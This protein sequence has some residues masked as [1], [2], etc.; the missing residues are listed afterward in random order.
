MSLIGIDFGTTNSA[1]STVGLGGKITTL[2]PFPSVGV[3]KNGNVA[4]FSDARTLLKSEDSALHVI[5]DLK[6]K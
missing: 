2:G 1:V 5:R 3:W 4:F 6:M